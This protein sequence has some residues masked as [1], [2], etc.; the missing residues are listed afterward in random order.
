MRHRATRSAN[1]SRS[2]NIR[3]QPE[4]MESRLVLSQFVVSPTGNDSGAG[5]PS[6][7]W[8][9]LQHAADSIHAGDSVEV[10]AGRYAGFSLN[11]G[12]AAVA[13]I[14]I[15]ADPGVVIS[16][17]NSATPDGIFLNGAS[18]VQIE[19]FQIT[20]MPRDG[21]RSVS[22]NNDSILDNVVAQNVDWGI[23]SSF[24]SGLDVE[25]NTVSRSGQQ[26][27]IY[28]SGSGVGPVL[29]NNVVWGNAGPGIQVN[30]DATQGGTGILAGGHVDGNI[31]HDNTGSTGIALDGTQG[32]T[33]QNNLLYNNSGDGITLD[34]GIGGSPSTGVP[35][36]NNTVV[37]AANGG[38]ALDLKN[39]ATGNSAFNNIL[40]SSPGAAG[41]LAVSADSLAGLAS[42][43][44]VADRLSANGGQ[45][46]LTLA[47]WQSLV[48]R[49]VHSF[50]AAQSALFAGL[51]SGDYHLSASSPA[52]DA[53]TMTAAPAADLEGR[54]RPARNG[55]DVGAYE[56]PAVL[57]SFIKADDTTQG[58]WIGTYGSQ[59][60]QVVGGSTNLP[61]YVG[62]NVTGQS[63]TSWNNS[64]SDVRGLER[65]TSDTSRVAGTYYTYSSF[66]VSLTPTDTKSHQVALYLVDWDENNSRVERV[67][68]VNPSDGSVLDS[69]VVSSFSNG[70]YLVW[71]VAGP[72]QFR[73][74]TI[75]GR[76]P[77]ENNAVLSGIFFDGASTSTPAPSTPSIISQGPADV[78]GNGGSSLVT[79]TLNEAIDPSTLSFSL[80]DLQNQVIPSTTKYD[81]A[82]H[83]VT[84]V[85]VAP[86]MDNDR[87]TATLSGVQ[88][89]PGNTMATTSWSFDVGNDPH[90]SDPIK[91]AEHLAI[92]KLVPDTQAT[93]FAV[94]SGSWGDPSIWS[95]N[96]VPVSGSR[97]DIPEGIS[98]QVDGLFAQNRVQAL[99]VEGTLRFNPDVNT[100]LEVVTT[101]V[102]EDGYVEIGTAQHRVAANVTAQFI[103][104]NRG[105]RDAAMRL[106]D[107]LDY[108]GGFISHG[109]T[110]LYG[111]LYTT[112]AT[113]SVIPR[114]GDTSI[115]LPSVPNGWKVGDT[116]LFA[117]L[118]LTVNQDET[119]TITA[120]SA[121][122]LRY[123]LSSPLSYDHG[124]I[125]G[126]SQAAPVGNMTRNVIFSSEDPTDL[127]DRGHVMF[128]HTQNEVIDSVAFVGLGRTS[129]QTQV[130]VPKLD[131]NGVL[132]PGTD[133]NTT[134]RY[135]VHFHIRVGAT[136][137]QTPAVITNSVI[138]TSPKIGIDNHGGYAL[139]TN[140]LTYQVDGSGIFTENGSEIG[141][142][143]G[144]MT[145]RSHGSSDNLDGR[146]GQNGNPN[147]YG[148]NGTGIW[149]QGN[150]V[151]VTDNFSSGQSSAAYTL[152][153][154]SI[155]D[156]SPSPDGYS[157]FLTQNLKDPSVANGLPYIYVDNV[158][159]DFERNSGIASGTG[160]ITWNNDL[161]AIIN[162]ARSIIADS[163]FINNATGWA[164]AYSRNFTLTNDKFIG[165]DP[166][167]LGQ[168]FYDSGIIGNEE[169][170]NIQL[171]NVTIDGYANG[172]WMPTHGNNGIQGGFIN[173]IAK[174]HVPPAY[175]GQLVINGVTWGTTPGQVS[176]DIILSNDFSSN[177]VKNVPGYLAPMVFTYNGQTVYYNGQ[178]ANF[179]PFSTD[180]AA[181]NGKTNQ[182]LWNAYGM[183]IGGR[184][185]PANLAQIPDIA[186]GGI[187]SNV[188]LQS[189][190]QTNDLLFGSLYNWAVPQIEI[191]N[192]YAYSATVNIDGQ[193][194][195][196]TPT[197][198][199]AGWNVITF[200]TPNG[201]RSILVF[202]DNQAN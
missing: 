146:P 147:D 173:G 127:V 56:L 148:F 5:T 188:A 162:P 70:R 169:T 170:A 33:A 174:V 40:A 126:Y 195:V 11:H 121:D 154:N 140:N 65:S 119:K 133:A 79:A 166:Q 196:S 198:L 137:A 175:G 177:V 86:L 21:I 171:T 108:T 136:Y 58:N 172:Y 27:G 67:D 74:T 167:K 189:S 106:A 22:S 100:S 149:T 12:G 54:A 39:G 152:F 168:V 107:P 194:Y 80:T 102:G 191:Y 3:P 184:I 139:I 160:I 51:A 46:S 26:G 176:S 9:T 124:G 24:G 49:D 63:Q 77:S 37:V 82:R 68:V 15:R 97:V 199:N 75:S 88:Q 141:T 187:G 111:A 84:L 116:L 145:V 94:R 155:R 120:V 164:N 71:N 35:L 192:P 158:P 87:Y 180:S 109:T 181:L 14:T 30:G 61:S 66:T 101:V 31:V 193:Q 72:V 62:V 48:G 59:G 115:T 83:V 60:Y 95:N 99:F 131:A 128:M 156:D 201:K 64:Q 144:N 183:A 10:F 42:D 47:Q 98:V 157:V 43:Y 114:A 182:Q 25:G 105:V 19:G 41:S 179:V 76:S 92:F 36:V 153:P 28:A 202:S 69:R 118:S 142:I 110:S 2:R 130:T 20:A 96:T 190:I 13:P 112:S 159:G 143:S 185:A 81:P 178:A 90:M 1:S 151:T 57:A 50:V 161:F 123:T 200:L 73:V 52:I 44:N 134:G 29:S 16:Q 23:Y 18:Y 125:Y 197:N 6:S 165:G 45:T 122:G 55:I 8:L 38:W 93:A 7:P 138:N 117:G 132:I 163:N 4:V 32:T 186:G 103:I 135:A 150:G 85:P 53:G 113:P 34:R 17:A 129:A 91:Q 104:G 78:V 89:A